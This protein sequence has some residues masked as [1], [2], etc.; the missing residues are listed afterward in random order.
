[1][2]IVPFPEG[3]GSPRRIF[4]SIN[5]NFVPRA[6]W[7]PDSRHM[8]LSFSTGGAQ[9]ALWFA[10][11]QRESLRKLTASTAAE[12]S[13][14]LAPDGHRLVFTSVT[15]DFDLIEMPLDGSAPRTLLATSRNMYS[16]SW[17]RDGDQ[18]LYATDRTGASE[19]WV[20]NAKA[21]IDRP[22]VTAR[23]FPPG[24]T[25]GLA[26]PVFSPDGSRFAFVRYSTDQP[27]TIWV[28]PTV[29]GAPIRMA[30][31]YMVSPTWSPDGNSIAGLMHRDRPWQP[32]IVQVG[33]NMS[34]HV[35][36]NAPTC[37]MPMEW[38][39]AG[40]W[41]A[42]EA[43]SGIELFSPD[44]S[45]RKTLPRLNSIA[46]AFTR[47]GR[48]VYAAGRE[49]GHTFIKAIDI[50]SG[51]VRDIAQHEGELTIS[52]GATYQARLI[53]SPDGRSLVTSAL[54]SRSD[55]WLLEGFPHPRPWWQFWR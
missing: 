3:S 32:A 31:E 40:D 7:M 21:S 2:W 11:P 44:G 53:L 33:A 12:E 46:I 19:I 23:D 15:D 47:D 38:S 8:V 22:L 5:F 9:S 20:H 51:N 18:L 10:D 54:D 45:K 17:S 30:G 13:P 29:G 39:P 6:S 1:M 55:L 49:A 50:A 52:G 42:C 24:T 36:A 4:T 41:L 25:T 37:L 43:H 27:A 14:S 48:A 28:E 16:P 26:H 35:I 34:P